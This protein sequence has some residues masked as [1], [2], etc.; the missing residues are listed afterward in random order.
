MFSLSDNSVIATWSSA[1]PAVDWLKNSLAVKEN[2]GLF[3]RVKREYERGHDTQQ[4]SKHLREIDLCDSWGVYKQNMLKMR[5]LVS[6]PQ[7]VNYAPVVIHIHHALCWEWADLNTQTVL[8]QYL[9]EESCK[10]EPFS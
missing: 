1:E 7:C 2:K 8:S 5:I 9:C 6:S 10:K 3:F 4:L